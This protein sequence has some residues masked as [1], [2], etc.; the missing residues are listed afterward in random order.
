MK[1]IFVGNLS[2]NTQ[3]DELRHAFESHGTVDKV[4]IISDRDT[5]RSRGF[6]FVEMPNDEEAERAIAALDGSDFGGRALK[7][8]LARP[9]ESSGAGFGGGRRYYTRANR[10][11]RQP[12]C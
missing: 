5:G 3:E 7:V 4:S 9:R 6:A 11:P 12:R 1:N 2:F 8:N 10:A